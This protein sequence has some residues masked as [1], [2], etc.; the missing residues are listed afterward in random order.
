MTLPRQRPPGII[1]GVVASE[2]AV[3]VV[4]GGEAAAEGYSLLTSD[5]D[6]EIYSLL[7]VISQSLGLPPASLRA[8]RAVLMP[9]HQAAPLR[10]G[11]RIG[12]GTGASRLAAERHCAYGSV[13]S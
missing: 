11:H 8:R 4:S 3:G 13:W 12:A 10:I 2:K 1:S 5:L 6:H 7:K 9:R